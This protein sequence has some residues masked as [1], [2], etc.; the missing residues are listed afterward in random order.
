MLNDTCLLIRQI[1]ICQPQKMSDSPNVN[2]SKYTRYTVED[3]QCQYYF[4]ELHQTKEDDASVV[5]VK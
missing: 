4:F 1:K 5:L 3:L 2:P